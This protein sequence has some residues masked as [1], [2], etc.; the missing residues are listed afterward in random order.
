MG[1]WAPMR[2]TATVSSADPRSANARPQDGLR[3]GMLLLRGSG[4]RRLFAGRFISAFGSAMAP[5]GMAFGVLELTGSPKLMGLVI[6]SQTAAQVA[7]QLFC[8]ALADRWSR[9]RIMI[10]GDLLAAVA[11][12][13]M[14][15]LLLQGDARIGALVGLMAVNGLAFALIFPAQVGIV[16]QVVARENL[17]PANALLSLAQSS[18]YGLGGACAGVLVALAGAGWAIALDAGTFALSAILILGLRPGPQIRTESSNLWRE[19]R[20]GWREFISHRWLWAIVAQFSILL[21]AWSGAFFVIGPIVAQRSL[22]GAASWGWVAG[23]LGLGLTAGGLLGLRLTVRR[24]MLVATLCMFTFAIPVLL[25]VAPSPVFW[26]ACGAFLAGV[27]GELFSVLWNTALHTHVAPAALSRVSAYDVLG[28]IALAPLGEALA[29]PLVEEIGT[30]Q[31]LLLAAACIVLPTAAVLCVR[32]V[33]TLEGGG[34]SPD[35]DA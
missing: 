20:D 12:A 17:Q 5:V 23:A 3:A 18:A 32:E 34:Y 28:S 10:G 21:A 33:R 27:G 8:G 16:P 15:I 29:G 14:A 13:A 25:L 26:I 35:A 30:Q 2:H 1:M 7:A 22:D 11:Q 19:L 24:P 6:A 9:K 31:S 4:F